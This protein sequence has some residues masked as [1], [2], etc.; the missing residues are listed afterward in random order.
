[1]SHSKGLEPVSQPA[2]LSNIFDEVFV[3]INDQQVRRQI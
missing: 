2:C 3:A 1:M